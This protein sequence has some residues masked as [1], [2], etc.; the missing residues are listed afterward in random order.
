MPDDKS[1]SLNAATELSKQ[2]I[3]L[4]SVLLGFTV[5]F[6]DK[7]SRGGDQLLPVPMTLGISWIAYF[8]SILCAIWLLLAIAGSANEL[9]SNPDAGNIYRKNTLIPAVLAILMFLFAVC[10][11]IW[12]GWY[13][14]LRGT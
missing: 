12:S 5:T 1:S 2:I 11:T 6:A 14:A 10:L 3:T 4:S 9:R 7:F 13:I 8:F